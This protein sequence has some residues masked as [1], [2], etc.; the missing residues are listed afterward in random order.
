MLPA[1]RENDKIRIANRE[2][3]QW[4]NPINMNK[5]RE[6]LTAINKMHGHLVVPAI[7]ITKYLLNKLPTDCQLSGYHIEA[8]A[9]EAFANYDGKYTYYDTTKHLLNYIGTR[10]HRQIVDVT[11]QSGII[12]D[13]LGPDKSIIRQRCSLQIKEI[14]SRFESTTNIG[15]L[16]QLFAED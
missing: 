15:L 7:K 5:F 6:K 12:D 2:N 10:V 11:G 8:I 9:T 14:S 4:S 13:Y 1:L 3:S 16:Q